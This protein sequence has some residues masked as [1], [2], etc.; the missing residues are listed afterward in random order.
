MASPLLHRALAGMVFV[1]LL[2]IVAT[3]PAALPVQAAT[4]TPTSSAE[5]I[6]AI[7]TANTNGEN[8]D[9]DLG[10][11]TFTLTAVDNSANGLPMILADGGHTLEIHNG[12]IERQAAAPDFRLIEVA[13]G[14][15][16][17][18]SDVTLRGGKTPGGNMGGA[19][20]INPGANVTISNATFSDNEATN[21]SGG[22]IAAS[23]T[24]SMINVT[25]SGNTAGNAALYVLDGTANLTHVSVIANT[26]TISNSPAGI[27]VVETSGEVTAEGSGE[28]IV[29][30]T[31][32]LL[33]GNIGDDGN[34]RADSEPSA[35]DIV[36]HGHNLSDDDTCSTYLDG[37]GDQ[38][39]VTDAMT[40]IG[41]LAN[42]GGPTETHALLAGSTA[43]DGV[44]DGYCSLSEDQ[45][46]EPRPSDTDSPA[47]CDIG[48]FELQQ[49]GTGTLTVL[50]YV[51][52]RDP[53]RFDLLIDDTAYAE[54]V[55]AFGSTGAVEVDAGEY[56][57]SEE[58]ASGTD[59]GDYT[60]IITCFGD[61]SIV[62]AGIGPSLTVDVEAGDDVVCTI[63]NT[64]SRG[65][66]RLRSFGRR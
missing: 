11:Q 60:S 36:T 5:L 40:Y 9:I 41:P 10:G 66:T 13:S 15:D 45:R 8:D 28:A 47:L 64:R 24:V 17:Q 25:L 29:N 61:G 14:S 7:N 16:L 4:P 21:S 50:K 57:V 31:N 23:G 44:G 58:G 63:Y 51:S 42:N 18:L 48:A 54:G 49:T 55:G 6:T 3:A 12:T 52:L 53:G 34:C 37:T 38:N 30:L 59:L 22:A 39:N 26:A 43:I 46:G 32:T 1:L 19:L 33:A 56:T 2:T 35:A 62:A 20:K 65:A 27:F